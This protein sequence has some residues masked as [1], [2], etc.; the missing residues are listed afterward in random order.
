MWVNERCYNL[1]KITP[2]GWVLIALFVT[3]VVFAAVQK[4][5]RRHHQSEAG[6]RQMERRKKD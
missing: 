6:K 2:V 1:S 5:R 4:G 3:A